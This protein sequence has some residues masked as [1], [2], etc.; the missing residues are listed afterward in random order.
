MPRKRLPS[1]QNADAGVVLWVQKRIAAGDLGN[2][3]EGERL[4]SAVAVLRLVLRAAA[5][6][7]VLLELLVALPAVAVTRVVTQVVFV[8]VFGEVELSLYVHSFGAAAVGFGHVTSIFM[9]FC[10]FFF[11]LIELKYIKLGP[12]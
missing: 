4:A 11:W 1:T 3:H 6:E 12:N 5:R 7:H 2:G 8:A 10:V 9:R